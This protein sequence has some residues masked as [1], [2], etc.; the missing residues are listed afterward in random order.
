MKFFKNALIS[1]IGFG[2]ILGLSQSVQAAASFDTLSFK[3]ATDHGFYI[4]TEGSQ[5]LGQNKLH[6]TLGLVYN[7]ESLVLLNPAGDK[8]RNII[9]DQFFGNLQLA[10]GILEWWNIGFRMNFVPYQQFLVPAS[11]ASDTGARFGDIELDMKFR[12]LDNDV[13]PVGIALVPFI[14]FPSGNDSHFVGN[15]KVTGGGKLVLETKRIANRFSI[16]SNVG[17]QIRGDTPLSQGTTVNDQFLYGLGMNFAFNES[18]EAIGELVGWTQFDNFFSSDFRPM[19]VRGALRFFP[20]PKVAMT[21]GGGAGVLKGLGAPD[22]EVFLTVGYVPAYRHY[23]PPPPP[24]PCPDVDNDGLC[25]TDDYCPAESGSRENCGCPPDPLIYI[26]EAAKMIRNQKIYF[27]FDKSTVKSVSYPILNTIA[28]TLKARPDI[29]SLRIVGHTDSVGTEQYNQ[30]LSE[31]RANAVRNY[32]VKQGVPAS[33]LDAIG[34]GESDPIDTNETD[35]G[36]SRNRRVGF[37]I[38]LEPR[39]DG[40]ACELQSKPSID[41]RQAPQNNEA[42]STP[43]ADAAPVRAESDNVAP[44]NVAD[45]TKT[46]TASAKEPCARQEKPLKRCESCPPPSRSPNRSGR[47]EI[48]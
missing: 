36:R 2:L 44:D 19:I 47:C 41:K 40:W 7:K 28:D 17:F 43:P 46:Q 25:D 24:P 13:Y 42:K 23:T 12:L 10:Y 6:V 21:F 37:N 1:V 8:V 22:F 15:G 18:L 45:D 32:L 31:R 5:T 14:T 38:D 20:N 4:A 11:G 16:S 34:K 48:N 35:E 30:G 26:D 29:K 3:P 39:E 27:D 9:D 33:Q